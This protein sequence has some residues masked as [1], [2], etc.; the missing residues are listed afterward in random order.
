[1][2]I[3][4]LFR[5]FFATLLAG[6]IALLLVVA[7]PVHAQCGNPPPSSCAT[8]HAKEA[9]VANKGAWHIVH[10]N[11]DICINCHGGNGSTMDKYLAHEGMVTQPLSDIY[12]DCHSCHPDYVERAAP[13]AA[14]LQIT[15]ASCATST[16]V[17]SAGNASNRLPPNGMVMSSNLVNTSTAAH[18]FLF[19][20]GGIML[21]VLFCVGACWL[22][23]HH[24]KS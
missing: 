10:A 3:R 9:P 14:T 16:P 4:V 1:M 11:K 6:I 8:C 20:A 18:T 12:T 5:F 13:Y 17:A 21:L 7:A 22:G 23:E 24:V 15:P 19:V 2:N